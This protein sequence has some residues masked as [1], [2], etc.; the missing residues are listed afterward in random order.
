MAINSRLD[1]E[2]GRL[3]PIAP[4][5]HFIGLHVRFVSPLVILQD[6]PEDWVTHY[7]EN[8]LVL[9]DPT[10]I[11]SMANSGMVRWSELAHLDKRGVLLVAASYGLAFGATIS[12]GPPG[13][14][15]LGS[16]AR[17]DREFTDDEMAELKAI[18]CR[19]HEL[20]QPAEELT[21]AQIEALRCVASGDRYA[22]AA[23]KLGISLSA[24]KARL[25]GAR[26]K[27]GARTTAEAIQRAK[28]SRLI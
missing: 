6:Y 28:D 7:T 26:Q 11:W 21:H 17:S 14:R 1:I 25:G 23:T 3:R 27:L 13:S 8:A 24:F 18:L 22:V 15:S 16:F 19:L 2:I 4:A 20:T 9:S 12:Y 10:V 5:G